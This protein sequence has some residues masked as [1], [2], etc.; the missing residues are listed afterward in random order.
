M[1]TD[2]RAVENF[3]STRIVCPGILHELESGRKSSLS[4]MTMPAKKVRG[5]HQRKEASDVLQGHAV[6]QDAI[7]P[8]ACSHRTRNTSLSWSSTQ[9]EALLAGAAIILF[10]C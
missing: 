7:L 4:I 9:L 5:I 6:V 1:L 3:Q 2:A 8:P 10:P